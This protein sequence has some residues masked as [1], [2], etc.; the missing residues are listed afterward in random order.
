MYQRLGLTRA[1]AH[2]FH[3]APD[4]TIEAFRLDVS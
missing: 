1:P 2:D 4:F 3:P